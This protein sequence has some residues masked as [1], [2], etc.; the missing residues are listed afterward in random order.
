MFPR[1]RESLPINK[2]IEHQEPTLAPTRRWR[3]LLLPPGEGRDEGVFCLTYH[4]LK[5]VAIEFPLFV[6]GD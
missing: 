3:E 1:L 2:N 5:L 6:R 4:E